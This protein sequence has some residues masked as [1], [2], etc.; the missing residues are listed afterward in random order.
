M[1]KLS[2]IELDES[3]FE[4]PPDWD[5]EEKMWKSGELFT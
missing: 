3:F 1:E 5:M 2:L 4:L